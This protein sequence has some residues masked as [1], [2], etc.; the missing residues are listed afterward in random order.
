MFKNP[1]GEF[2][3]L[4]RA[5]P[6]LMKK[7]CLAFVVLLFLSSSLVVAQT[8]YTMEPTDAPAEL[9]KALS[10]LLNSKGVR[11]LQAKNGA[12]TIVCEVWW[13]KSIE[14][15]TSTSKTST[16]YE[17]LATGALVGVLRFVEE[18]EDSRDQ[19]M[20]AGFYT[21]RYAK[22]EADP[23]HSDNGAPQD[24][25]LASPLWADKHPE[26]VLKLDELLR[27]SRLSAKTKKPVV[28]NLMPVNPAY[29]EMPALITDDQGDCMVQVK[30]QL[31]AAAKA[32]PAEMP[33][34]ILLVTPIR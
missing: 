31:K 4:H 27:V 1:V 11:L 7:F 23:E 29:T 22:V 18:G 3:S 9:P 32:K 15:H 33:V 8:P 12:P 28:I 10:A 19:K 17:G 21:L 25:V 5:G 24:A 20:Q 14:S 16:P 26:Q 13:A 2:S 30:I 6:Y 34:S